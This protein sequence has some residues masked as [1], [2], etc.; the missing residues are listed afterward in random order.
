MPAA[1]V[2]TPARRSPVVE[3]S[4]CVW[5]RDSCT[6][7]YVA[8]VPLAW[9][10]FS[11]GAVAAVTA[12]AA[13]SGCGSEDGDP[14]VSETPPSDVEQIADAYTQWKSAV[15]EARFEDA[16]ALQSRALQDQMTEGARHILDGSA[17]PD[18]ELAELR[19]SC[20]L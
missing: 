3:D 18:P 16:C 1:H 5:T 11:R 2:G 17:G 6:R 15:G 19:P 7:R 20:A 9:I 12:I 8:G 10:E 13:V 14:A 4:Q